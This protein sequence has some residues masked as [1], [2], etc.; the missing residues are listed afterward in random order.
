MSISWVLSIQ[1]GDFSNCSVW[2]K[3]GVMKAAEIKAACTDVLQEKVE[4]F[5]NMLLRIN[6]IFN[7]VHFL[8]TW[9][10]QTEYSFFTERPE[11]LSL[12]CG[13]SASTSYIDE[14]GHSKSARLYLIPSNWKSP[15]S[16][17]V[18]CQIS[19][20]FSWFC[21]YDPVSQTFIFQNLLSSWVPTTW[22]PSP[23]RSSS[24]YL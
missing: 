8:P 4:D 24:L 20:W 16:Y 3:N 22:P 15:S 18:P 13:P 21:Q 17:H 7:L 9:G 19:K 10:S 23:V 2:C 14:V 5:E 6:L 12:A 1:V 11:L